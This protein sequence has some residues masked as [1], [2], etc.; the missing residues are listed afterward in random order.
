MN[1]EEKSLQIELGEMSAKLEELKAMV[2]HF[3]NKLNRTPDEIADELTQ[4]GDYYYR[5]DLVTW[6]EAVAYGN[7][8]DLELLDIDE[9]CSIP[10]KILKSITD[11][12]QGFRSNSGSFHFR[13]TDAYF[14]SSS[15]SGSTAWLRFR[16]YSYDSVQR[17]TFSKA[18]GFSAIYKKGGKHAKER[19]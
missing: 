19:N 7:D 9:L 1:K 18:N 2:D 14:W 15:E 8:N 5:P 10:D 17:N 11:V 3:R 16:I 4:I 12:F 6:D 13:G